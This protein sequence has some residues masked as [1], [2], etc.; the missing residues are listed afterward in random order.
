MQISGVRIKEMAQQCD[1]AFWDNIVGYFPETTTGDLD[2]GTVFAL[3]DVTENL[4]ALALNPSS[5]IIQEKELAVTDFLEN[6]GVG[7][8]TFHRII[9]SGVA[10]FWDKL[11]QIAQDGGDTKP[12]EAAADILKIRLQ[13]AY[14]PA[15]QSWLVFNQ[16]E[17]CNSPVS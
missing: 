1:E 9:Q 11:M 15:L 16:P 17:R 8:A 6:T 5:D 10:A 4:V 13:N 7:A 2:P 12:R 3:S 14:A